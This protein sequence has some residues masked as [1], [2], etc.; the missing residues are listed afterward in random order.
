[1]L[2]RKGEYAETQEKY[3]GKHRRHTMV[4]LWIGS[5]REKGR[6]PFQLIQTSMIANK[7]GHGSS[8]VKI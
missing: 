1:M 5:V 3:N 6:I 2:R 8:F 7:D 4:F